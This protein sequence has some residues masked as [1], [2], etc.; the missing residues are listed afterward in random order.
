MA[1]IIFLECM[2]YSARTDPV[3]NKYKT[4]NPKPHSASHA[5]FEVP[6]SLVRGDRTST[7]DPEP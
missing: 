6:F 7:P 4:L 5:S 3:P 2:E 1:Y